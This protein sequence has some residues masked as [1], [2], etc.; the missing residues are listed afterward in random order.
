M[1]Y[2]EKIEELEKTVEIQEQNIA[3]LNQEVFN[4]KK[5]SDAAHSRE[6]NAQEMIENLRTA[7]KKLN[8]E[9]GQRNKLVIEQE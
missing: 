4:A 3:K 5:L 2:I 1:L 8:Q 7:V 6:Q 9:L